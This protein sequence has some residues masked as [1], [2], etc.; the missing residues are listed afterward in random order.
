MNGVA[1]LPGRGAA[2]PLYPSPSRPLRVVLLAGAKV[3]GWINGFL[4]LAG[5]TPWLDVRVFLV[6]D[7]RA[8][9]DVPGRTALRLAL[10]LERRRARSRERFLE[11]LSQDG[12]TLPGESG[13]S[14]DEVLAGLAALRPELVVAAVDGEWIEDA[15]ATA[16]GGCWCLEP[17]LRRELDLLSSLLPPMLQP[18]AATSVALQLQSRK[19]GWRRL[20]GGRMATCRAALD[21]QLKRACDKLPSLML[22]A[23]LAHAR[24]RTSSCGGDRGVRRLRLAPLAPT[25]APLAV[26]RAFLAAIGVRMHERWQRVRRRQGRWS[27]LVRRQTRSLD[28]AHPDAAGCIELAAPDGWYWAD[29]CVIGGPEDE[30]VYVEECPDDVNAGVIACLRIDAGGTAERIGVALR[31]PFHL[32]FPQLFDWRGERFMTVESGQDRR[33]TLYRRGATALDWQPYS[34]L[35]RGWPVVDPVLHFH[36]GH[37]YLFANVAEGGA[38]SCDS[39]FLFV[40]EALTGPYRPHPANPIVDDAGRAR[41]AGRLFVDRGRL[42]R[43]SQDCVE[44]YG[45]AVVFHEILEL[46]PERYRERR[47]GRLDAATAGARDGCHTYSRSGCMETIDVRGF[48]YGGTHRAEPAAGAGGLGASAGAA[49]GG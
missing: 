18:G 49:A 25:T 27:V 33:V 48:A 19:D 1:R 9:A 6:H 16:T 20:S 45:A 22:R 39:L 31:R 8:S 41:M 29:P 12:R 28:P 38:S 46:G 5:D 47:L 21:G 11:P 13:R 26:G 4:R 40:A 37:W 32:S 7:A 44:A 43:P 30:L 15:A 34:E 3:P 36:D 35:L 2:S 10:A 23:L 17:S 24:E 42:V 14:R